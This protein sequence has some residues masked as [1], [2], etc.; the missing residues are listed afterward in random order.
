VLLCRLLRYSE[1]AEQFRRLV[2]LEPGHAAGHYNLATL[3]QRAG[4][5]A[6]AR[7][8]WLAFTRLAPEVASAWFNLGITWMD[9]DEPVEA[10]RCFAM[11]VALSPED[12]AG[13]VNLATAVSRTG[14]TDQAREIL[15]FA[16][17]RWPCNEIILQRIS[18]SDDTDAAAERTA[19]LVV[20]VEASSGE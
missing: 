3:A 4:R 14:D 17:S 20:P 7:E 9:F 6:E 19:A 8:S 16:D 1:A 18:E 10:M 15:A 11:Y 2:R 13:Y 5:L 12:P